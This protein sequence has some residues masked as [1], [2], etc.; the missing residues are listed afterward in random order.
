VHLR[1]LGLVDLGKAVELLSKAVAKEL[2]VLPRQLQQEHQEHVAEELSMYFQLRSMA[3]HGAVQARQEATLA[4]GASGTLR[5]AVERS[6]VALDM[7]V[8]V[9]DP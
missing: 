8:Q 7:R 2:E 9:G 4:L 3:D 6:P 1:A 5:V